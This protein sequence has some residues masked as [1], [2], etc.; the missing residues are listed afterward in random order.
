[1]STKQIAR[2]LSRPGRLVSEHDVVK[3]LWNLRRAGE[4]IDFR[5][6]K[7]SAHSKS[8]VLRDIRVER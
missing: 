1:M 3:L 7:V 2:R 8:G 6:D 4:P 5:E